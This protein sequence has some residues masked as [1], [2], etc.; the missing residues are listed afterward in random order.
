MPAYT[1]FIYIDKHPRA[2]KFIWPGR[3]LVWGNFGGIFN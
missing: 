1:Q 2:V 3:K